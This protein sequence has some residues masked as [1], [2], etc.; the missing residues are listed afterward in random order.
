MACN[1]SSSISLPCIE[2][3]GGL[4]G[5]IWIATDFVPGTLTLASTTGATPQQVTAATGDDGSFFEFEVA[6]NV[7]SFQEATVVSNENS[8]LYFDQTLTFNLSQMDSQK[9][10][11]LLLLAKNRKISAI[12]QDQQNRYWLMG[13]TRGGIVTANAA[14]SG[15]A[16]AD[17]NGYTLTIVASETHP[18][19]N[20]SAAPSTIF[21]GCTFTAAS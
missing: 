9:R 5:T 6:K 17:L 8:S 7:A 16:L 10:Y 14:T 12:F 1:I 18:A 11:E 4:Q 13:D 20:L 2:A 15:V 21:T 3:A 19:Y